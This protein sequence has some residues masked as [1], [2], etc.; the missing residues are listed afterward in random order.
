MAVVPK[1]PEAPLPRAWWLLQLGGGAEDARSHPEQ[2][3][4]LVKLLWDALLEHSCP[5]A[6]AAAATSLAQQPL[7][8][9]KELAHLQPLRDVVQ[10]LQLLMNTQGW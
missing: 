3:A 5:V 8:L 7:E 9:V 2:Y 10:V 1:L 4:A 6:R